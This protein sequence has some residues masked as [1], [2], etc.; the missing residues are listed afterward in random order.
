[1]LVADLPVGETLPLAQQDRA[2]LGL[3][4]LLEH[5]LK[6]DQ[7][8]RAARRRG[9]QLLD[10][11]EVSRRLDSAATPRGTAAGQADVVRDLEEPGRLELGLDAALEAAKCVQE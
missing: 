3:R 8:V 6:T 2:A 9:R 7:L 10:E 5:V 4:H 11:L 1:E